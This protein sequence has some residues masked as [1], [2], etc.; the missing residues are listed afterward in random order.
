MSHDPAAR[1]V[2]PGLAVFAATCAFMSFG[3]A[4]RGQTEDRLK[5]IQDVM[6]KRIEAGNQCAYEFEWREFNCPFDRDPWSEQSW[7]RPQWIPAELIDPAFKYKLL[8]SR[9]DFLIEKTDP[10]PEKPIVLNN[11]LR[12][13]HTAKTQNRGGRWSLGIDALRHRATQPYPI[14][15]I[16]ELGI[17]DLDVSL[18]ELIESRLM[19][20]S[21]DRPDRITLLARDVREDP[22]AAS[23]TVEANLDP[24]RDMLPVGLRAST[25]FKEM[26]SVI[27]WEMRVLSTEAIGPTS[28]VREALFVLRNTGTPVPNYLVCRYNLLKVVPNSVGP[29]DLVIEAPKSNAL[30][31]DEVRLFFK[32]ID[33]EGRVVQE[34]HWT[35]EERARQLEGLSM[36]RAQRQESAKELQ[37]RRV[38]LS[39]VAIGA[40]VICA[41][42]LWRWVRARKV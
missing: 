23:W 1:A 28:I 10:R 34:Q 13:T 37:R 31:V 2:L 14:L 39:T 6:W 42:C 15:T 40:V 27:E 8:L 41:F 33:S 21:E 7:I 20:I 11:W 36:T 32:E 17:F 3:Y 29:N 38:L 25:E 22:E 12:G 19:V 30:I 26:G 5:T 35:P 16:F 4:A 18:W 9:P 24:Q